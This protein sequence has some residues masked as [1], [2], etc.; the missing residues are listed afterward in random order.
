ML[1]QISEI[2]RKKPQRL[3]TLVRHSAL[4]MT[5][6]F[7]AAIPVSMA[8]FHPGIT[9]YERANLEDMV[10]GRAYRPFVQRTLVP[11][12]VRNCTFVVPHSAKSFLQDKFNA[13]QIVKKIQWNPQYAVEHLI[14]AAV[15]YLSFLAFLLILRSFILNFLDL[16]A[17]ASHLAVFFIAVLLPPTFAYKVYIY[18]FPQMLL[19][20]GCLLLLYKQNWK[21]F[22]PLYVLGCINKEMTILIPLAFLFWMGTKSLKGSALLHFL[23]QLIVGVSIYLAINHIFRSNPGGATEWHL[24]RN[25]TKPFILGGFG[26]LRL[27]LF[28][29]SVVLPIWQFKKAPLFLK[30]SLLAIYPA[31]ICLTVLFGQMDEV[32]V[33]Y[34]ALP[35][36][37]TFALSAIGIKFKN[38]I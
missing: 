28:L 19:F 30:A 17:K 3:Q 9:G 6:L 10:Y 20:T 37:Y 38:Q 24:V 12:I 16:S 13:S 36:V 34:E 5:Y 23:I 32:R 8:I 7:F 35:V 1:R 27:L 25:L 14:T 4:S 15:M 31:L 33:Y 21:L 2:N 29:L 26:K 11:L 18:D 22:Y